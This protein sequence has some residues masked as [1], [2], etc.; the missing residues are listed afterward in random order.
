MMPPS[1]TP[2]AG[3]ALS[4][5]P[6]GARPGAPGRLL[7]LAA[8]A[9]VWTAVGAGA[10]LI[11]A[12]SVPSAVGLQL[13][14]VLSGSMEPAIGTGDIVVESTISPLEARV[15][16]VVTFRDPHDTRR[17]VTHRVRHVKLSGQRVHFTTKGDANNA[18]ERWTVAAG[19]SI[20]RVEYRLPKLGYVSARLRLADSRF[21]FVLVPALLLGGLELRRIWGGDE[22]RTRASETR[23][24]RRG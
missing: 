18:V 14:S 5:T 23:G 17:L 13:F 20:G 12:V 2:P 15:G 8:I 9:A 1:A 3:F 19:G 10:G 21:L 22:R 24:E 11:A 16:D 6:V 7:R 4:S